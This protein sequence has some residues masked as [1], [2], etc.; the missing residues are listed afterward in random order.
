MHGFEGELMTTTY[1]MTNAGAEQVAEDGTV[2]ALKANTPEYAAFFEWLVAGGVPENAIAG[3]ESLPDLKTRLATNIDARVAAIYS[4]WMR[5]QA[6][7][8]AREAAAEAFKAAGYAGDAGIWVT[9]FATAA[10]LTP[11]A[12]ADRILS[13]S[14]Q[15]RG[16][17]ASLGALRMRKYEVLAAA[18]AAA[19]QAQFDEICASIGAVAAAIQ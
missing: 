11:Q 4:T 10:G 1:R 3:Q 19:A 5:F 18:D 2:T 9:G 7:Y 13:Q 14:V 8:E 16:A 6:E 15:L 17:L 12:A